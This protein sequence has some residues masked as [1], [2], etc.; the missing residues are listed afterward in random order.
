MADKR[1]F[2]NSGPFTLAEL[3]SAS[4]ARLKDGAQ[5]TLS[6]KDVAPLET[7]GS[8]D[9]TFLDNVK[10][11][12]AFEKTKAGACIV[13]EKLA[14]KA[15]AGMA[16]LL[17]ENPYHAYAIVASMFYPVYQPQETSIHPS[18]TIHESASIGEKCEIG[19][20]VVIG[21]GCKVG[22]QCHLHAG[23]TLSDG[24]EI[25]DGCTLHAGVHISHAVVGRRVT[26]HHGAAI[27]QD[28]FGFAT[29]AEGRHERVPQLGRVII[30][31]EV[32]IGANTTIDRGSGPDTII[33]EGTQI[34]NL[35]QIGHN[36]VLGRG[37]IVVSQVGISGSTKVGD[38][39]AFGG[40]A[41]ITG[42]LTIGSGARIA[43]QSGVMRDVPPGET[44]CG[45][46]AIPAKQ[47]HRQTVTLQKLAKEGQRND[48]AA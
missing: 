30:G 46:P 32:N 26:V 45:S 8:G 2:S 5:H 13:R 34:D 44:I 38:F 48:D 40:Q 18:A 35:V 33:G 9:I 47:F 28:G 16:L 41:G 3:A 24:V 31:D 27:G 43:A 12:A 21:Q 1:F 29:S 37:C 14:A 10:Y 22:R 42:H 7:A 4:G 15:P 23:V 11:V 39:V 17:S 20:N 25:G 6:I 36:V 19:P